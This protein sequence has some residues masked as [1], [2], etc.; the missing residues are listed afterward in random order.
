VPLGCPRGSINSRQRP[1][2]AETESTL[3]VMVSRRRRPI[4]TGHSQRGHVAACR[5]PRLGSAAQGSRPSDL[6]LRRKVGHP[7]ALPPTLLQP[8]QLSIGRRGRCRPSCID[9]PVQFVCPP[10]APRCPT[11]SHAWRPCANLGC[12]RRTV[13]VA[14]MR[15]LREYT[16]AL[17][18]KA[19]RLHPPSPAGAS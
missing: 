4:R 15:A 13:P 12:R 7:L 2:T 14:Y 10:C 6:C 1:T 11:R 16:V 19:G 17:P 5:P 3:A 18:R 9:G 8:H